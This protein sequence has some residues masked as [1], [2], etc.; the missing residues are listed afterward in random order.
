MYVEHWECDWKVAMD[1]YL[2]SYHVPIGHPG[3]FRM[4]T[5]DFDDQ[6][7]PDTGRGARRQLA[8]RAPLDAA[9]ASAC[10]SR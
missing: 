5:P 8:A 10:T 1:N 3:L 9:G 4:F 6:S 2:E 7:S